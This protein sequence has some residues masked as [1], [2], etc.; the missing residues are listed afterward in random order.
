[1]RCNYCHQRVNIFKSL[2]GSSFCSQEHQK[3]YEKA[4]ANNAFERL[5][6]YVEKD[7]KPVRSAKPAE[8][9]VAKPEQP[10]AKPV[11]PV[12]PEPHTIPAKAEKADPPLAGFVREP[13]ASAAGGSSSQ[14]SVNFE[15]LESGFPTGAP[16]LPCLNWRPSN[17][18]AGGSPPPFASWSHVSPSETDTANASIGVP[19]VDSVPPRAL[20]L[21]VPSLENRPLASGIPASELVKEISGL[22]LA[23]QA[24][25]DTRGFANLSRLNPLPLEGRTAQEMAPC[26]PD[27]RPLAPG[28]SASVLLSDASGLQLPIPAVLDT[29]GFANLAQLSPLFPE[30]RT[31]Q[32]MEARLVAKSGMPALIQSAHLDLSVP[33]QPKIGREISLGVSG[34]MTRTSVG[35]VV[36]TPAPLPLLLPATLGVSV[37]SRPIF[38]S[39]QGTSGRGQPAVR[40]SLTEQEKSNVPVRPWP[41]RQPAAAVLTPGVVANLK[42]DQ[43]D[44]PAAIPMNGAMT[45]SAMARPVRQPRAP[46]SR[47]ANTLGLIETLNQVSADAQNTSRLPDYSIFSA[48]LWQRECDAPPVDSTTPQLVGMGPVI[49]P[50]LLSVH[51]SDTAVVSGIGSATKPAV[52]SSRLFVPG[53]L[54]SLKAVTLGIHREPRKVAAQVHGQGRVHVCAISP[55]QLA[56]RKCLLPAIAWSSE[57][58]L[59][60]AIASVGW[61]HEE[62]CAGQPIEP[63]APAIR[64]FSIRFVPESPRLDVPALARHGAGRRL[65]LEVREWKAELAKKETEAQRLAHSK[66]SRTSPLSLVARPQPGIT[67]LA[68]RHIANLRQFSSIVSPAYRGAASP[69]VACASLEEH[70]SATALPKFG[71]GLSFAFRIPSPASPKSPPIEPA[72]QKNAGSV[73]RPQPSPVRVQPASMLVLPGLRGISS[74]AETRDEVPEPSNEG[75]ALASLWVLANALRIDSGVRSTGLTPQF[76]DGRLKGDQTTPPRVLAASPLP[77]RSG[78]KLP[79]VA[80]QMDDLLVAGS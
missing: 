63:G 38:A 3:L 26:S 70:T 50:K 52:I 15:I 1:M 77:R 25:L 78:P 56:L 27:K 44:R 72:G 7:P 9:S 46:A 62:D 30:A 42:L 45:R 59:R 54:S 13:I 31:A 24:I 65:A 22:Q 23:I 60:S 6:Q 41:R 14:T 10:D 61:F 8:P 75:G 55:A 79:A 74:T 47:S 19:A 71:L 67:R 48:R 66:P 35:K 57:M 20:A 4:Q 16:A 43:R 17:E 76:A 40:L 32:E 51:E 2:T 68:A 33:P 34:V 12:S 28:I 18:A 69:A 11:L 21:A 53:A 5:L 58:S 64:L 29:R 49:V 37:V 36:A 80:S 73:S 39:F